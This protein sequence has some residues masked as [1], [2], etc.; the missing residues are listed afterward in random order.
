MKNLVKV[1]GL[2]LIFYAAIFILT[3]MFCF[4]IFNSVC[5]TLHIISAPLTI[6]SINQN[7]INT[8]ISSIIIYLMIVLL[9]YLY[10]KKLSL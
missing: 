2:T 1:L 9:I 5:K 8:L 7:L 6:L 10:R 4:E 3:M